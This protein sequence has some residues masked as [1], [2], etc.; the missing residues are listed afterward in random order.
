MAV[1]ALKSGGIPVVLN[2][3]TFG[4]GRSLRFAA[5]ER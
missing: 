4:A 2:L 5:P 1:R 3:G